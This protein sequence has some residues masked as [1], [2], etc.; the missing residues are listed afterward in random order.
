[1]SRSGYS[2]D[3]EGNHLELYRH[4]VSRAI[5]GKRGQT[6]LR[7][8]L[9]DL[10]AMPNKRLAAYEWVKDGEACAL[11]V[12]AQARGLEAIFATFYPDDYSA[13]ENAAHLLGIAESMARELV[14]INDEGSWGRETP[15]ERWTRVRAWVAGRIAGGA[16]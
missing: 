11:G 10:D 14:Y 15:E 16:A 2:D 9:S 6:F 3:Y 4:A 5:N 13:P 12:A 8:L 1:M 7:S